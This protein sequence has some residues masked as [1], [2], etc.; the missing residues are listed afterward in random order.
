MQ[1]IYQKLNNFL[2]A[3]PEPIHPI[4]NIANNVMQYGEE[5]KKKFK[6]KMD[7]SRNLNSE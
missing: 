2:E 4:R 6:T 7:G 5:L 3:D 1:G